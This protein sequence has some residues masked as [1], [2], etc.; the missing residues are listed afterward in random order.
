MDEK[1][2]PGHYPIAESLEVFRNNKVAYPPNMPQFEVAS[3]FRQFVMVAIAKEDHALD[4][5]RG[6]KGVIFWNTT[7]QFTPVPDARAGAAV[8]MEALDKYCAHHGI[9]NLQVFLER[10]GTPPRDAEMYLEYA[11]A[12]LLQLQ[13]IDV[14]E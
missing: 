6:G 2:V 12:I 5:R 1:T 10:N 9:S 13:E 3:Q 8:S 4:L 7:V 11:R 14:K